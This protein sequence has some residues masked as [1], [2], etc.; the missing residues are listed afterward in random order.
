[1]RQALRFLAQFALYAPLMVL[2]GVFS[3]RPP[4]TDVAPGEALVR[5]SFIH[6]AELKQKCRERSAA[7]LAK[8]APNMRAALDCPRE[9]AEI[10]VELELDGKLILRREVPPTGLRRDGAAAVYFRIKVPAGHHTV[11]ARMRDRPEGGFDYERKA[12]LDLAPGAALVID[13]AS[14]KGGFVFRS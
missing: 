8:L 1:M 6:A 14:D 7:E 3:T 4:F 10:H 2:I 13:F 12:T 9:R 5:L 11:V